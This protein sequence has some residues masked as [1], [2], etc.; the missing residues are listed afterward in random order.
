M[1]RKFQDDSVSSNISINGNNQ[2]TND[3]NSLLETNNELLMQ[4]LD[5]EGIINTVKSRGKVILEEFE[6]RVVPIENIFPDCRHFFTDD[7]G[8]SSSSERPGAGFDKDKS[9]YYP[10]LRR[11]VYF[12]DQLFST[13]YE[14][15][16]Q[17]IGNAS[18][19]YKHILHDLDGNLRSINGLENRYL[20]NIAAT[21]FKKRTYEDG[22]VESI[23]LLTDEVL[24]D[25][26]WIWSKTLVGDFFLKRIENVEF[27]QRRNNA[28]ANYGSRDKTMFLTDF[29]YVVSNYTSNIVSSDSITEF[30]SAFFIVSGGFR[31]FY[32]KVALLFFRIVWDWPFYKI[33]FLAEFYELLENL[34]KLKKSQFYSSI[35]VVL[36]AFTVLI[37]FYQYLFLYSAGAELLI[38]LV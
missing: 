33:C 35:I 24:V 3:Q 14:S 6:T 8:S 10:R 5:L 29:S 13:K 12:R 36:L 1:K 28:I 21:I 30:I 23:P 19:F 27:I 26:R 16:S 22:Y 37:L 34:Q 20:P 25:P 31:S 17:V 4:F 7:N 2:I 11:I 32:F 9:N 38:Y 15:H 18:P